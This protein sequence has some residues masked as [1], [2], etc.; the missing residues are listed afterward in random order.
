[1]GGRRCSSSV[2]R[3]TQVAFCP[4][5]GQGKPFVAEA[6]PNGISL[7]D[8]STNVYPAAAPAQLLPLSELIQTGEALRAFASF[9]GSPPICIDHYRFRNVFERAITLQYHA[10][11]EFSADGAQDLGIKTGWHDR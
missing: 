10:M 1:M 4:L 2:F 6:L 11:G 9:E 8:V 3:L 5:I 7:S